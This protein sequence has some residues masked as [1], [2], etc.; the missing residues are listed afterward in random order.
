MTERLSPSAG[1]ASPNVWGLH[2]EAT[3]SIQY[4]CAC[5][6][7]REAALIDVVQ[8]FEPAAAR[9]SWRNAQAIL[10]IVEREGLTVKWVLDTHPHADHLLASFWLAEKTGA[11]TAIGEKVRE[12]ADLW[13]DYYGFRVDPDPSFDR[14][15][16]DGETLPLGD[17]EISVML[18]PGHTLASVTYVVGDAAFVHDTFM[19]PD[20]GTARADFPGASVEELWDS[21]QRILSLADETRLFVGH[22]YPGEDRDEPEWEA[23]VGAH[24]AGNIHLAG[25]SREDFIQLRS[26]RDETLDLPDRMLAALQFNLRGGRPPEPDADGNRRIVLPLDRF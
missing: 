8:D 17:L 16:V 19:Q 9:R 25:K 21:L 15:L 2:D 23:T 20:S 3:G 12:V 6:R 14:L 11:P 4:V 1:P 22:D 7:T 10:D 5:P 13:A 24:R 18:T 26:E